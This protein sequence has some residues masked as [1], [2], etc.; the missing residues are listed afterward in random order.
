MCTH[1]FLVSILTL[2]PDSLVLPRHRANICFGA[3]D[4]R[5]MS[6]SLKAKKT[7][8]GR[9]AK[10]TSGNRSGRP[11][12]S[13]NKAT[14][15]LQEMLEGEAE[16]ITRKAIELAKA[17]DLLAIRLCMERLL[18]P[19]KDRPVQIDLPPIETLGQVSAAMATVSRAIGEGQITPGEGETL[20]N[21]LAVQKDVIFNA[22][23]HQRVEKMEERILIDYEDVK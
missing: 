8:D 19:R 18:P 6:N 13:R 17:G 4:R 10:G 9:W 2:T 23:L 5:L 3:G 16:Q 12:G 22:E 1:F 14:Q 15:A 21:I 20:I 11:P 7:K